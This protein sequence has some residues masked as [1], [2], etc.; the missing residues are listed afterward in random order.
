MAG[1]S[2][3]LPKS[4][5]V[6]IVANGMERCNITISCR[7]H[8]SQSCAALETDTS[9]SVEPSS[10]GGSH[11]SVRSDQL[12]NRLL[13]DSSLATNLSQS[14]VSPPTIRSTNDIPGMV[15]VS[16]SLTFPRIRIRNPDSLG[17]TVP[18][19]PYFEFMDTKLH[20]LTEAPFYYCNKLL[21]LH[22][23]LKHCAF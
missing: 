12:P 17:I 10:P 9:H 2:K 4:I 19:I 18:P 20:E 7:P 5:A 11:L 14:T 23:I 21:V 15:G 16:A 6:L 13:D 3:C 1:K 22:S 8:H